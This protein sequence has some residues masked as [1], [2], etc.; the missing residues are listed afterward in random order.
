MKKC[1]LFV[2]VLAIM[3]FMAEF[4]GLEG[5]ELVSVM[6][7][8]P[9]LPLTGAET[10][11]VRGVFTDG[12][13]IKPRAAQGQFLGT[14]VADPPIMGTG[15]GYMVF[16]AASPIGGFKGDIDKMVESLNA[17]AISDVYFNWC[18]VLMQQQW[19][20]VAEIGETLREASDIHLEGWLSHTE[21]QD[22][23]AYKF[24]DMVRGRRKG[25][26]PGHTDSV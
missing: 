7:Q 21:T 5:L 22:I 24:N 16:G 17:F 3:A 4:P 2:V 6:S 10:A 9:L 25:V 20:A 11:L 8:T 26:G 18:A 12:D 1:F 15:T 14:V 13:P 23:M 19:G